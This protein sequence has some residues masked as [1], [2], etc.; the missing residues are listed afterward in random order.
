MSG[1]APALSSSAITVT[2][3]HQT[4]TRTDSFPKLN[5]GNYPSWKLNMRARLRSKGL[6]TITDGK[7]SRPADAD[8]AEKWDNNKDEAAGDLFLLLN[9]CNGDYRNAT[10]CTLR[11]AR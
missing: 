2:G 8:K 1:N 6:W 7:R 11:V 3:S 10:W 5:T 9:F 4:S